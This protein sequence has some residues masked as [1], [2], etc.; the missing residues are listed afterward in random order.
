M[1]SNDRPALGAI[2]ETSLYVDDFERSIAFYDRVLGL[3]HQTLGDRGASFALAPGSVLLIWRRGASKTDNQTYPGGMI[4]GHDGAGPLHIAFA[5][6]ADTYDAW[7]DRLAR[8][9]IVVRSEVNWARGGRSLYFDD[10][11][12]HVLELATPGVWPNY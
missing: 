10:P 11:D 12:G 3:I 8:F 6:P 1:E 9:G 7:K 5:I 2:L 4:P